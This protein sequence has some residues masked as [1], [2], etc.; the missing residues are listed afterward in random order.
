VYTSR[1][2]TLPVLLIPPPVVLLLLVADVADDRWYE[3]YEER[4]CTS[5]LPKDVD[6]IEEWLL[7]VS[8]SL[9]L[10][11][12]AVVGVLSCNML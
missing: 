11:V 5:L 12:V 7:D 6:E 8:S 3:E 9:S 4:S 10:V 2:P 1:P